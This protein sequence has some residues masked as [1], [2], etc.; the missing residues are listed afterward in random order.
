MRKTNSS[1]IKLSEDT[2]IR[3]LSLK[4]SNIQMPALRY[5]EL[6]INIWAPSITTSAFRTRRI[7]WTATSKILKKNAKRSSLVALQNVH[8]L[9]I[10]CVPD[11]VIN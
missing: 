8:S 5:S 9:A 7:L 3:I 10:S 1:P 11:F 4:F 6:C 2:P